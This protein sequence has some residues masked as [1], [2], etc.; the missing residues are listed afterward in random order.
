M[1]DEI[2]TDVKTDTTDKT[3]LGGAKTEASAADPASTAAADLEAHTKSLSTPEAKA[4]WEKLT[5]EQR[6]TEVKS[7]QAK[8]SVDTFV[9][10]LSDTEKAEFEKLSPNDKAVKIDASNKAA[11]E[12]S[13]ETA[14]AEALA[15]AGAPEKYADF[16]L[17]DGFKISEDGGKDLDKLCRDLNLSQ[18]RAQTL[19]T[20]YAE[21]ASKAAGQSALQTANM[22]KQWRDDF[23]KDPNSKQVLMSAKRGI[24]AFCDK[25]TKAFIEKEWLGDHPGLIRAFAKAAEL[26]REDTT[27]HG[28]GGDGGAAKLTD[29]QIIYKGLP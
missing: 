19:I 8:A 9:S 1:P 28:Q 7:A 24:D 20:K 17:P 13:K 2:K 4:A 29:A 23:N 25:D 14:K 15:K 11:E 16:K 22:Q 12:A 10:K 5:P 6:T 21:V 27:V 3:L 18:D 26:L